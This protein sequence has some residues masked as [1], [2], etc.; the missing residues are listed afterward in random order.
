[1]LGKLQRFDESTERWDVVTN[2]STKLLQSRGLSIRPIN[3]TATTT[4]HA[5]HRS[6]FART[7]PRVQA[8]WQHLTSFQKVKSCCDHA[9][10]GSIF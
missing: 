2:P 4:A 6:K 5:E 7:D 10:L 3:L 1:M 8:T 9:A